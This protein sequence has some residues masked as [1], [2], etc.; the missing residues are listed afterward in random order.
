MSNYQFNITWSV[1]DRAYIATCPEFYG[2]SAFGDTPEEALAE[3][4]VALE[5]F[6]E[7]YKEDGVP[8]PAP[9]TTQTHS[10]Q[11]R[12]RL[13]R[14]LHGQAAKLADVDGISLNQYICNAVQA[15][16]SGHQIAQRFVSEMKKELEL[17]NMHNLVLFNKTRF[18]ESTPKYEFATHDFLKNK[19]RAC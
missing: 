13:P 4:Q 17:H 18:N 9:S 11:I 3:A 6:I 7:T 10:G 2:L 5:L 14:S 19:D 8:L 16:V 1:E 12:L 15:K